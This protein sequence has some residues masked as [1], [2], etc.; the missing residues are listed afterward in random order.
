MCRSQKNVIGGV[1]KGAAVAKMALNIKITYAITPLHPY[2]ALQVGPECPLC[3][4]ACTIGCL[5]SDC[6][7]RPSPRLTY[8]I[9]QYCTCIQRN[10]LAELTR[11]ELTSNNTIV[12]LDERVAKAGIS[13][14]TDIF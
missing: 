7:L 13:R 6:R 4:L 5:C 12:I 3:S 14:R 11:L 2:C 10:N 8:T 1:R 9:L